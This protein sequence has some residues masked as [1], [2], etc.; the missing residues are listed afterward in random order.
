M[1]IER[2]I[3]VQKNTNNNSIKFQTETNQFEHYHATLDR[4]PFLLKK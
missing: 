3:Q 4:W 1:G 2:I